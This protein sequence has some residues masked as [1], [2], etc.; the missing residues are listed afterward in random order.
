MIDMRCSTP[1]LIIST[2]PDNVCRFT[3]QT[4]KKSAK[5]VSGD[6]ISTFQSKILKT[7]FENFCVKGSLWNHTADE[8]PFTNIYFDKRHSKRCFIDEG[9]SKLL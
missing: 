8:E 7:T 5:R 4:Y 1:E 3:V 2:L 6:A 9:F